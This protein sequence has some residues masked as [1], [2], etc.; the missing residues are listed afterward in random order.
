MSE[1]WRFPILIG[2]SLIVFVVILR[3]VVRK[4]SHKPS[5]SLVLAV[6][7]IVVVGGMVVAKVTQ[8]AGW[9]WWIYYTVPALATLLLPPITF[10]FSWKELWRYLVLAF[11][12]APA[13]HIV[14]SFFLGWHDYMPFIHVPS[15]QELLGSGGAATQI[16]SLR[17]VH[18][19]IA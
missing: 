10:R 8:N 16:N 5:L 15:L 6:S 1:A 19:L 18:E 17:S 2:V 7:V 11:L 9:P 4:R 13:I 12:S 3:F 14:F